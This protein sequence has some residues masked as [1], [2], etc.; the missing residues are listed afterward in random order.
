MHNIVKLVWGQFPCG[1]DGMNSRNDRNILDGGGAVVPYC[2]PSLLPPIGG[3][4]AALSEGLW[5]QRIKEELC[6]DT[7]N[8]YLVEFVMF[9]GFWETRYA[10]LGG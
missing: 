3:N 10:N 2:S 6:D 9:S 4:D 1:C 8:W 7:Y 5:R